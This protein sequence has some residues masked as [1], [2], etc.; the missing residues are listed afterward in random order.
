MEW[1]L[2]D[3]GDVGNSCMRIQYGI[4]KSSDHLEL[5]NRKGPRLPIST[6]QVTAG[7]RTQDDIE[8]HWVLKIVLRRAKRQGLGNSGVCAR[9]SG[10]ES[11]E[12]LRRSRRIGKG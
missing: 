3:A 12:G 2:W 1:D 6:R 11:E 10:P 4:Y 9:K 7:P 8:C 5:E